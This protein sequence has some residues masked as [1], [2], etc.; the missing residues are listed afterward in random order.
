MTC[1]YFLNSI[2]K[3]KSLVKSPVKSLIKFLVKSPKNS[4]VMFQAISTSQLP[5]GIPWP[6][7]IPSQAY[8]KIIFFLTNWS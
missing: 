5:S 4:Q 6:S 7:Q 2:L 3:S 8:I 1:I